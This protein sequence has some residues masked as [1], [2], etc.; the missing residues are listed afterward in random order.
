MLPPCI[1]SFSRKP[2]NTDLRASLLTLVLLVWNV[3]DIEKSIHRGHRRRHAVYDV[4]NQ[5]ENLWAFLYQ[6]LRAAQFW[7]MEA[8]DTVIDSSR[9]VGCKIL[10]VLSLERELL[11]GGVGWQ[12]CSV[13][14]ESHTCVC[15]SSN[16]SPVT[17]HDLYFGTQHEAATCCFVT[18]FRRIQ[19]S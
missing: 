7:Y 16:P 8:E 10:L 13:V 9:C 1:D 15:R 4:S 3:I 12:F 18:V 6:S 5:A 2:Y 19:I 11:C 14:H 17:Q